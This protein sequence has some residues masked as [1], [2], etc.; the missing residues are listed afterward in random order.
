MITEEDYGKLENLMNA[1]STMWIRIL[2]AGKDTEQTR[3]IKSSMLVSDSPFAPLYCLRKD[4]KKFDDPVKGPP[5]RPVCGAVAAYNNH[6]SHLLSLILQEVWKRE[7]DVCMS[8]EEMLQGIQSVNN[9]REGTNMA[10]GSADVKA[11]YPSLD[12][13]FTVSKVCDV[14]CDSGIQV[15]GCDVDE[16]G[17]YLALQ[18]STNQLRDMGI[19]NYCPKRKT[20]RGRPPVITGCALEE[21]KDKRYAPWVF[22]DTRPSKENEKKMFVA[23]LR[24]VLMFVMRNHVYTFNDVIY[25]Q[26]KGGPIGLELTGVLAQIFMVWWDRELK[27]IATTLGLEFY[28]YKRYV[29]DIN[30]VM[31]VPPP[32]ARYLNGQLTIDNDKIEED[33]GRDGSERCMELVRSIADT[34]HH[35]IQV[36]VDHP[37]NHPDGKWLYSTSRYGWKW[38]VREVLR[39]MSSCTNSIQKM[40]RQRRYSM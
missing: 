36:E 19:I 28:M 33:R 1:H 7:P 4:H 30:L 21:C 9:L 24:H 6:L 27:R 34:I 40:S 23:A 12:I 38:M 13:E 22:P 20:H 37:G 25:R 35:S 10:L 14:F 31:R 3:K 39:L 5:M 26:S 8:T 17:L 15:Q 29:D 16:L 32:G 11:L 2:Q 18:Y